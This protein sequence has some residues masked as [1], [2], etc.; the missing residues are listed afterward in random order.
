M[1]PR[2]HAVSVLAFGLLFGASMACAEAGAEW[3]QAAS[4]PA[5][6]WFHAAGVGAGGVICVFGGYVLD[7]ATGQREFGRDERGLVVYDSGQN[8]WRAGPPT[9]PHRVRLR[10]FGHLY[11]TKGSYTLYPREQVN[12]RPPPYEVPNGTAGSDGRVYWFALRGPIFFDPKERAWDQPPMPERRR[13]RDGAARWDSTPRLE[14]TASATASGPDGRIYLLGGLGHPLGAVEDR[15]QLLRSVEVYDPATN[16]W[17]EIAPMARGRQLFAAAFGPDGR[18]YAFGGYGHEGRVNSRPGESDAAYD[19]RVE[20]MRRFDHA[21]DAVEAW[22]PETD[23]WT[24]RAPMPVGVEGMGAALGADGRIYVVGGTQTYPNPKA[25]RLVQVYD[26]ATDRWSEG[27]PLRTERQGHAVV[28]TRDGRIWAIGGTN[29]HAVF[30]PRM[31]VG[32]PAGEH[33]G[34]LASVEVLETQ[35]R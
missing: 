12:E 17:S 23:T 9:P 3:R 13:D 15:Y 4:L 11:D 20:E 30:H 27:P 31:I 22:D 25:E 5:P 34:P 1:R 28:A 19:A 24:P 16:T 14:R 35:R 6:R 2:L 29:A 21:L 32:G 10:S 18:L 7:P 8:V 26:P 33:G